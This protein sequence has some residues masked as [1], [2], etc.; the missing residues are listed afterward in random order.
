MAS[1]QSIVDYI[2]DQIAKAGTVYSRK[3]FG[4][5]ALYCDTKVVALVCDDQLFVKPTSAGKVFIGNVVEASPYSGAKPYF[6]I[7]GEHWDDSQWLEMLIKISADAL[8]LPKKK[9]PVESRSN[10]TGKLKK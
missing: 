9:K 5:Y 8:P 1:R 3:M 7:S 2:L 6:L 4:E 10:K